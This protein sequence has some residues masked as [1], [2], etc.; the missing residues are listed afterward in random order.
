MKCSPCPTTCCVNW[1]RPEC[2]GDVPSSRRRPPRRTGRELTTREPNPSGDRRKKRSDRD[3]S[4]LAGF[5]EGADASQAT[6]GSK[7]GEASRRNLRRPDALVRQ[8]LL[9]RRDG[10]AADR[11]HIGGRR[12]GRRGRFVQRADHRQRDGVLGF[13]ADPDEPDQR[14]PH[15]GGGRRQR[16]GRQRRDQC[17]GVS[18]WPGDRGQ[19][20]P[21]ERH[22]DRLAGL[23][24][25]ARR[26]PRRR[27]YHQHGC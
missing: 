13:P 11:G 17:R 25:H 9:S 10:G 19:R 18:G 27:Q 16:V 22:A 21:R 23:C 3:A 20:R 8:C 2:R 14:G 5:S 1:T 7:A 12:G 4:I 24:R 26:R 6:S 15:R